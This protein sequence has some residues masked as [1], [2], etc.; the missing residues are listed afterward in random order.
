MKLIVGLGNP[1]L[2]YAHTRHNAGFDAVDVIANR[3]KWTWDARRSHALLAGGV[4]AGNKVVLAKPQTYMNESGIAVG[5][6][7]RFYK[8]DPADLLVI[9][10]DLDL[11]LGRVRLRP[12]GSA[13]GQ[14]G[15]ESTISHLG[16][17]TFARIKI[18]VGRPANGH[19]ENIGFLLSV[20][21]GDERIQLDWAIER[22][23][24]AAWCWLE[25]GIDVAMNRYNA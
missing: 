10:D 20:P 23:A 1:G 6:L 16:T 12:G 18:G 14:H 11:P 13:G 22:A 5:E 7:V 21:K 19:D 8:I 4:I 2:R 15:L 17:N 9:C 24:D 3:Q 25:E